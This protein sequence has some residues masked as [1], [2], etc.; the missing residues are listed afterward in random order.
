MRLEGVRGEAIESARFREIGEIIEHESRGSE[1]VAKEPKRGDEYADCGDRDQNTRP[2]R[3]SRRAGHYF[4][5][6][7]LKFRT[8]NAI[9]SRM[10]RSQ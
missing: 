9:A 2:R 6:S 3:G 8:W 1:L 10:W 5:R 4:G 7:S